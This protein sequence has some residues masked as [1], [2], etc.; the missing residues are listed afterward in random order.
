LFPRVRLRPHP[1]FQVNG[2]D[3]TT[4]VSVPV[5]TAVLGGEVGVITLGGKTV[6]VKVPETSQSGMK[7]RLRGLGLPALSPKD[8]AGDLYVVIDVALPRSLNDATRKAY[9]ELARLEKA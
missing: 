6:R 1:V 4:R 7:L 8:A 5:S 3:L 2:R 9:E